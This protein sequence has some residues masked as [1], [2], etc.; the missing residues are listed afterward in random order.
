MK[1]KQRLFVAIYPPLQLIEQ[2]YSEVVE[3]TF[4]NCRL[5]DKNQAHL[6]LRFLGNVETTS[7]AELIDRISLICR[8]KPGFSI[9]TLGYRHLPS[10]KNPR[11]LALSCRL[12]PELADL[13]HQ[14]RFL[15]IDQDKNKKT[16]LPH[17]TVCRYKRKSNTK[18][19]PDHQ[20]TSFYVSEIKLMRSK[21]LP[22]KAVHDCLQ[23]FELN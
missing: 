3:E 22:D 4:K 2:I 18:I 12:N 10:K 13:Y 14:C 23:T 8:D 21:L 7:I 16:F 1:V 20:S 6:T 5:V 19:I 11:L 17:I 9:Q 15:L